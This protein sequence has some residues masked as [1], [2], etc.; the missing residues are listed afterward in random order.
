M[1]EKKPRRQIKESENTKIKR[2]RPRIS[3]GG[4][5]VFTM[6]LSVELVEKFDECVEQLN[7]DKP[8][9]MPALTRN[10]MCRTM[11]IYGVEN[12]DRIFKNGVG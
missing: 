7:N 6:S 2:G 4:S 10:A 9:Y 12:L 8:D 1:T 11:L 5:R 3:K